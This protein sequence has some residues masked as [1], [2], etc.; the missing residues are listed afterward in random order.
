[1]DSLAMQASRDGIAD[2]RE[3][4]VR[5]RCKQTVGASIEVDMTSSTK[6]LDKHDAALQTISRRAVWSIADDIDFHVFG[7][8]AYRHWPRR[9]RRWHSFGKQLEEN[10]VGAEYNRA[11]H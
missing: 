11:V 6:P 8:N 4:P 5:N 10:P 2:L 9:H 7:T 3:S 1:M